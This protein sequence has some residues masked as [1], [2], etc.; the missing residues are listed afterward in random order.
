MLDS[1]RATWRELGVEYDD[2]RRDL[3]VALDDG[4]RVSLCL[5]TDSVA[6]HLAYLLG[7]EH[8]SSARWEGGRIFLE[9]RLRPFFFRGPW[10]PGSAQITRAASGRPSG[11]FTRAASCTCI[12]SCASW[13]PTSRPSSSR[14]T[15][16]MLRHGLLA[17]LLELCGSISICRA[18]RASW[19]SG[20][21]H[22][23]SSPLS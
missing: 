21:A 7:S 10:L 1:E 8:G 20:S 11:R 15:T 3:V 22:R 19:I 14:L 13:T 6:T 5:A 18:W 12:S 9:K 2:A 4:V 16:A 23:S 17:Y